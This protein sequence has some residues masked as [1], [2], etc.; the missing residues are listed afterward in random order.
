MRIWFCYR[1]VGL[2]INIYD[3]N[4]WYIAGLQFIFN[5]NGVYNT[6]FN[7]YHYT[8]IGCG[9]LFINFIDFN[10]FAGR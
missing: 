10:C 7:D 3:L 2:I 9:K 1:I 6:I 4:V 5:E 8:L